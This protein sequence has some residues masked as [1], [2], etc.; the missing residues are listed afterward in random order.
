MV[1]DYIS[2]SIA[3]GKAFGVFAVSG[4]FA[5]R[6]FSQAMF[7]PTGGLAVASGSFPLSSAGEKPVPNPASDHPPHSLPAIIN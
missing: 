1:G 7:T 2:T 4:P 6:K 5:N 3:G